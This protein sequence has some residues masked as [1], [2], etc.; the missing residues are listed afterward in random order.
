VRAVPTLVT[1][2]YQAADRRTR[3][4]P[5]ERAPERDGARPAARGRELAKRAQVQDGDYFA[6]LG[7]GR[8][9]SAHE[10]ARAFERLKREFAVERFAEPIRAE[11][12]EAL[13]EIAEVLDEAHRVL[14][15]DAVRAAYRAHLLPA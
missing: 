7:L 2:P 11:L 4:R 8:D 15:D 5:S 6:V 12:H 10:V 9:A 13:A 1:A 14:A 3:A